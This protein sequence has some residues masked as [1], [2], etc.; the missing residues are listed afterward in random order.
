MLLYHGSNV[1]F[2]KFDYKYISQKNGT[3]EGYGF[4]FTDSKELAGQYADKGYFYTIDLELSKKTL[5]ESKIT[6]TRTQLKKVI[7][8]IHGKC[9]ILNNYN[10]VERYGIN[11]VL[12][13]YIKNLL[14][15]NDNDVDIL[16]ELCNVSGSKEIVLKCFCEILGINHIYSKTNKYVRNGY[17]FNIIIVLDD[18]VKIKEVKQIN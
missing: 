8:D 14:A 1:K 5:N 11:N 3:D 15:Y 13:E 2:E 10:D 9:D 16:C 17:D 18:N 7:L 4:Y 6:L 12:N